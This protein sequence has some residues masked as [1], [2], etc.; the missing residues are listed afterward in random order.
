MAEEH[1]IWAELRRKSGYTK[2]QY[3]SGISL[4]VETHSD[5]IYCQTQDWF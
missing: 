1:T 4:P 3:Y 5:L 2:I